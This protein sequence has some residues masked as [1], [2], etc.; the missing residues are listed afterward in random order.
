MF[1]AMEEIEINP[2]VRIPLSALAYSTAR[3]SGAGGQHVNKTETAVTLRFDLAG[4]PCLS[5][6]ERVRALARLKPYVTDAGEMLLESQDGRSQLRNK[7]DV[8]RRFAQLLR[9][10]L[11]P[12]VPRRK[13]RPT[14]SSV[15]RRL[16][17]KQ[18]RAKIKRDRGGAGG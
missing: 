12:P 7:E 15:E 16:E 17:S 18:Q 8:T 3:S 9:E 2:R 13:T 4:T 11:V 14:R 10:A 5:K 1:A 6:V